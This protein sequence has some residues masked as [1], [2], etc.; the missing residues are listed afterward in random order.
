MYI[1]ET[2]SLVPGGGGGSSNELEICNNTVWQAS[3]GTFTGP[4]CLPST[5]T[6]CATVLPIELLYFKSYDCAHDQTCFEWSTAN[7]HRNEGFELEGSSNGIDFR[8]I[9]IVPGH[10]DSHE[11]RVYQVTVANLEDDLYFR[12]KQKDY[13][14]KIGYSK[15]IYIKPDVVETTGYH[16]QPNP[17]NGQFSIL[18]NGQTKPNKPVY[19]FKI[20]SMSGKLVYERSGLWDQHRE[21]LKINTNGKIPKGVYIGRLSCGG[22]QMLTKIIID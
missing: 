5:L 2:G 6:A 8:S 9:I 20:Y 15:I 16:I 22:N 1:L 4:R 19:D 18:L 14:G 21:E 7:E 12:L 13:D 3:D 17:S 11:T 10:G